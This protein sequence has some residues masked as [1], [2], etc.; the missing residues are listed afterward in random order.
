[1]V[2][3]FA[4]IEYAR[5]FERDWQQVDIQV[6]DVGTSFEFAS[7]TMWGGLSAATFENVCHV[8]SLS[9]ANV[10]ACVDALPPNRW[11][12][13]RAH[14]D[15]RIT[16]YESR[17][18]VLLNI[19]ALMMSN[20]PHAIHRADA[21]EALPS[22]DCA[23]FSDLM[24]EVLTVWKPPSITLCPVAVRL[25]DHHLAAQYAQAALQFH[26]NPV[27]L[28]HAHTAMGDLLQIQERAEMEGTD[29]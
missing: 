1:M 4:T 12:W 19:R 2:P 7:L 11:A 14:E 9:F 23:E 13:S 26:K 24:C 17:S 10:S 5:R 21:T 29:E 8:R 15:G 18:S 22:P 28:F 6:H 20:V 27:K 16:T 25:V 3:R